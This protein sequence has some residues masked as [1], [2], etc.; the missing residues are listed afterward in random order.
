[1]ARGAAGVDAG[2]E[3]QAMVE[4]AIVMPVLVFAVLG[5]LQLT[6]MQQARLMLE[7]A[8]FQA[9]RAGIVWNGDVGRMRSAAVFALMPT[10][11]STPGPSVLPSRAVDTPSKLA[12]A[13]AAFSLENESSSALLGRRMIEVEVLNPSQSDFAE[14]ENEIEFDGA[15][16]DPASRKR[17]QLVIRAVYLYE[18]RIPF[19]NWIFFESWLVSHRGTQG[20]GEYSG[21]TRDHLLRLRTASSAGRYYLPLVAT[22][23]QRM[24]S[25]LYRKNAR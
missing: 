11:P 6:L 24:Q 25:N 8:A 7:Y 3:G 4:A 1:M 22:H 12:A 16:W 18:L 21:L 20:A 14:G 23:T 9:A 19:A 15:Q 10:F 17:A 2:E 5:I 13:F